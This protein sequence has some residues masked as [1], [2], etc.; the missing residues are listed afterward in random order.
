M[1][2]QCENCSGLTVYAVALLL[3]SRNA[4]GIVG[5]DRSYAEVPAD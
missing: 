5:A 2:A 4:C 3:G 1:L